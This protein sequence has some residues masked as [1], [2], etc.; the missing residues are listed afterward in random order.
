MKISSEMKS[1]SIFKLFIFILVILMVFSVAVLFLFSF[2]SGDGFIFEKS[3]SVE[4][5][6]IAAM[7]EAVECFE[8]ITMEVDSISF[9]KDLITI[10]L[11]G[12][13]D[14]DKDY[15]FTN[16]SFDLFGQNTSSYYDHKFSCPVSDW[17]Y[18]AKADSDFAFSQNYSISS[19]D[20]TYTLA[21]Y[22]ESNIKEVSFL[23][24]S[25]K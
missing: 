7:N 16:S 25:D 1:M 14:T 3:E 23:L 21:L 19:K 12:Y 17:S 13:N 11:T 8:G 10:N 6:K 2:T 5:S 20:Y 24:V 15:T 9:K 22:N 18:V 4:A